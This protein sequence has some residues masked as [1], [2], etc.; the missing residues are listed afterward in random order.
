[1]NQINSVFRFA[2]LKVCRI[3]VSWLRR[4]GDSLTL[5][6]V[7]TEVYSSDKRY[8]SSYLNQRD[9]QLN[10]DGV[11]LTDQGYYECQISSHPPIVRSVYLHVVVPILEI[12]DERSLPIKNKFYNS[13]ST[14]ELK[15]VITKVPQPTQFIIWTHNSTILNYDTTRGGISVKTDILPDGARSQLYINNV[16]PSDSGNYTCSLGEAAATS[17][18]VVVITGETPAAMQHG[19]ATSQVSALALLLTAAL[20]SRYL[21]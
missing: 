4:F 18:S 17:V 10:I 15:C 13:G 3:T 11:N 20:L 14:I 1:M 9:W 7:G 21:S 19:C 16:G 2:T 8:S 12:A 5:V 6:S